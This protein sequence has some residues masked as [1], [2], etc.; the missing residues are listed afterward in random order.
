MRLVHQAM[1]KVF[2]NDSSSDEDPASYREVPQLASCCRVLKNA[3]YESI[4]TERNLL[5]QS[6]CD[7]TFSVPSVLN[8]AIDMQELIQA[9][10]TTFENF[11]SC[12]HIGKQ[13][14]ERR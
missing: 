3:F 1:R 7:E 5:L 6:R 13:D 10:S 9:D 14:Y 11:L 2:L 4:Q 12:R 8:I